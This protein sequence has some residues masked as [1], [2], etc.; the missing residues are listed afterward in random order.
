M[1]KES[2]GGVTHFLRI[3]LTLQYKGTHYHGW[4]IQPKLMTVQQVLEEKLSRLFNQKIKVMGCGRTDAGVHA[5]MYAC[6]FDAEII[7][8]RNQR[9]T[10]P[11]Q[12]RHSL[13]KLLPRDIVVL[14]AKVVPESFHA[15]ASCCKKTYVYQILNAPLRQPFWDSTVWHVAFKLNLA[16]MKKAASVLI[17]EHDFKA[18]AAADGTAKTS[19]RK[20]FKIQISTSPQPMSEAVAVKMKNIKSQPTTNKHQLITIAVTGSGFL[21]NMVRNIVGTLVDIGRGHRDA[22]E[23]KAILQSC[24]RKQAGITAPPEGLFLKEVIY[25]ET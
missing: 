6:H 18:F 19:V 3:V 1:D 22:S 4:Q 16:Q 15:L 21:K 23:M 11:L 8:E 7:S 2:L 14:D 20:I 24:D 10:V 13:N 9:L 17:G 5:L 12:L 25:T